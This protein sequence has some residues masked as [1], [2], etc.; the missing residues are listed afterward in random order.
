[1]IGLSDI[2][3]LR[4]LSS[5]AGKLDIHAVNREITSLY[6]MEWLVTG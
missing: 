1:M 4:T 5:R 3:N 6:S 2:P